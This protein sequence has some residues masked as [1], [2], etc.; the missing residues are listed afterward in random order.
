MSHGSIAAA[1]E[2]CDRILVDVSRSFALIIPRCPDPIDRCLCVGYLLCRL[3]DTIEDEERLSADQRNVL[4]DRL[5]SCVSLPGGADTCGQFISAWPQNPEGPCGQLVRGTQRVLEA[6]DSLPASYR[7]PLLDCVHEMVA[8]MRSMYPVSA[9]RGLEFYCRDLPDLDRYCHYVAGTVGVMSTR[10]FEQ[11][12]RDASGS[13]GDFTPTNAWRERGRRMGLGLQMTNII[14]DACVDAGRGVSFIPPAFVEWSSARPRVSASGRAA[15]IRHALG[16]LDEAIEYTLA[17]PPAQTGIR[18]FL[19]GSILPAVATL[20]LA[21]CGRQESPKIDRAAMRAIL[22]L[23]ESHPENEKLRQAYE[24]H[25]RGC[26]TLAH[27][28]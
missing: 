27:P 18:A 11:Y 7:G 15:L 12:L 13:A 6:F 10:L 17:I 8:G 14:K 4:Y 24:S 9:H 21:A 28:C 5:L 19:L 25:R 26:L 16:H 2:F 20:E 23:I 22:D 3:A 1:W